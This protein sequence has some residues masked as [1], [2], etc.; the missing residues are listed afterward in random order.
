MHSNF[1][2]LSRTE[3][4]KVPAPGDRFISSCEEPNYGLHHGHLLQA[5]AHRVPDLFKSLLACLFKSRSS[6]LNTYHLSFLADCVEWAS[7]AIANHVTANGNFGVAVGSVSEKEP[8]KAG[9]DEKS[10]G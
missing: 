6:F 3:V 2:G 4:L 9:T 8:K 5:Y 10:E 1:F 7:F